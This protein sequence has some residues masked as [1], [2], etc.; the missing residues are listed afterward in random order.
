MCVD[1]FTH[2]GLGTFALESLSI[3][4][5]LITHYN[6][7][8]HFRFEENPPVINSF[9]VEEIAEAIRFCV[10]NPNE[11]KALGEKS[12][13]WLCKYHRITSYNVCYTKLLRIFTGKCI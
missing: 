4:K 12:R 8:K 6:A 1:Q 3:G 2:G 9:S 11:M 13:S 7:E 10:D 5:P